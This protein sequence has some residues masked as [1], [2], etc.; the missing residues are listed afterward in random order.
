MHLGNRIF[1]FLVCLA[2]CY[3]IFG[4]SHSKAQT[5]FDS[6]RRKTN[7]SILKHLR[8][9]DV[10]SAKQILQSELKAN[11]NDADL[12]AFMTFCSEDPVAC[13]E[14]SVALKRDSLM[15][16]IAIGLAK[17]A[18]FGE[19]SGQDELNKAISISPV[20]LAY[21]ARGKARSA[22]YGQRDLALSDFNKAIQIDQEN[23]FSYLN[24]AATYKDAALYANDQKEKSKNLE[25]ALKDLS[26]VSSLKPDLQQ[27][28]L[29]RGQAFEAANDYDHAAESY[30][31]AIELDRKKAILCYP[32]SNC[33]EFPESLPRSQ[34]AL[35]LRAQVNM[36][37]G[38]W[39]KAI[40]DYSTLI[41]SGQIAFQERAEAYKRDK[42]WKEAA[43]D[44]AAALANMDTIALSNKEFAESPDFVFRKALL[45][46]NEASQYL[47]LSD[48]THAKEAADKAITFLESPKIQ[49]WNTLAIMLTNPYFTRGICFTTSGQHQKAIEDY[50]KAIKL[51]PNH[52]HYYLNRAAAYIALKDYKHA[53]E[54]YS[55]VLELAPT[56]ALTFLQRGKCW[57]ALNDVGKAIADFDKAASFAPDQATSFGITIYRAEAYSKQGKHQEAILDLTRAIGLSDRRNAEAFGNRAT[58]YLRIGDFGAAMMDLLFAATL[59]PKWAVCLIAPLLIALLV[60]LGVFRLTRPKDQSFLKDGA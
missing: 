10:S 26:V 60:S 21:N 55:K 45:L 17:N 41:E 7:V 24:R 40:A 48:F 25:K 32:I 43:R 16:N 1:L 9:G 2:C 29:L 44:F 28:Y 52:S 47:E 30:S 5:T 27:T 12:W 38:A 34:G 39:K 22:V 35:W 57:L 6:E 51:V 37:R 19:M 23:I 59:S 56:N 18:R 13:A 31:K 11:Q 3:S 33:L 58:E 4:A 46:S 14:K 42:Q 50:N 54:D 53:A 20:S 8:E 49:N 36:L 15:P